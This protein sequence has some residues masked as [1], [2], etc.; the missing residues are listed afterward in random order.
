MKKITIITGHYGAGKSNFAVNLALS[1]TER[2]KSVA[3]A[4]LD[5]VN[6]YFRT[7][8]FAE[9][10]GERGIRLVGSPMFRTN[11]DVTAV[12]LN[13]A[14]VLTE[15]DCL[16]IDVG[17]DGEGAKVL[18]R[19]AEEIE[20]IGDYEMIYVINKYRHHTQEAEA[21]ARVLREIEAASGLRAT[22]IFNNSHLCRETTAE[23]VA[24]SQPFAQ[25][26]A[27]LTGLPPFEAEFATEVY[28]KPIWVC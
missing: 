21:A 17:G 1:L 25:E 9:L 7:A 20:R 12:S 18:G 19:F 2:G 15:S 5:I 11:M 27:A 10:F 8:D 26:V 24:A 4:D 13:V 6:P 23:L 28:V 16:I 3:V 14:G 22:A